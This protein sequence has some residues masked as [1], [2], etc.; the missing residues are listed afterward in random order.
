[1]LA[2]LHTGAL[3]STPAELASERVAIIISACETH[4]NACPFEIDDAQCVKRGSCVSNCSQGRS[5]GTQAIA[6]QSLTWDG[7]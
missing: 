1:M 6:P 7:T 5:Q 4:R 2:C 3:P